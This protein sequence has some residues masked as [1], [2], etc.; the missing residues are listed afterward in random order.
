[1]VDEDRPGELHRLHGELALRCGGGV[2]AAE[3]HYHE[4]I[5]P[6]RRQGARALELRAAL[7]TGARAAGL[8]P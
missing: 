2:D 6:A 4:A 8:G 5:E 7:E 3:Q 1:V